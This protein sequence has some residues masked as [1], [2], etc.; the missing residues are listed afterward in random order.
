M[1]RIAHFQRYKHHT[2]LS[3]NIMTNLFIIYISTTVMITFLVNY[4]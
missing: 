3:T 4:I 2:Q 1:I